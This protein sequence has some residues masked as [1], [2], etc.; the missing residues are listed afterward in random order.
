[1]NRKAVYII[2]SL[3]A[4]VIIPVYWLKLGYYNVLVR[5]GLY[6]INVSIPVIAGLFAVNRYGVKNARGKVLIFFTVGVFCNLMGNLIFEYYYIVD[7]NNIPSPS[8]IDY[9]DLIYYPFFLAALVIEVKLAHVNWKRLHKK[10]LILPVLLSIVLTIIVSYLSIYK[11]YDP[12]VN[13][14]ANIV[15]MSYGVGDLILIII[16]LFLFVLVKEYE[17]GRMAKILWLLL[18]SLC[19]QIVGDIFLAIYLT[20][21]NNEV[22]FYKSFFDSISMVSSLLTAAMLFEYGFSINDAYKIA[23]SDISKGAPPLTLNTIATATNAVPTSD[24]HVVTQSKPDATASST[25]IVEPQEPD[26]KDTQ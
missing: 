18:I 7:K 21:Y 16:S 20:Q 5:D 12:T 22:W 2:L 23:K 13:L 6:M 25:P 26:K 24:T 14:I 17:G 1:M 15:N 3:F 4:L 10:I 11:A 8:A 19:F 9:F